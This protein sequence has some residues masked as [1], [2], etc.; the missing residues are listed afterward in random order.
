MNRPL[1]VQRRTWDDTG[2]VLGENVGHCCCCPVTLSARNLLSDHCHVRNFFNLLGSHVYVEELNSISYSS[3][4][5]V[6][7]L[8]GFA[9]GL[10]Q[11]MLTKF[12]SKFLKVES[13]V[14]GDPETTD[15]FLNKITF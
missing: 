2:I 8:T 10:V 12:W 4:M 14:Q 11:E 1:Y 6:T 3:V 15:G 7:K 9:H 5:R 13:T